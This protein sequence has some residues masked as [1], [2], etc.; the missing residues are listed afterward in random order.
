MSTE[1]EWTGFNATIREGNRITVKPEVMK[2]LK[3]K[4][5]DML[6]LKVRKMEPGEVE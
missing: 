2:S 1:K 5:G 3:L 6:N 4:K